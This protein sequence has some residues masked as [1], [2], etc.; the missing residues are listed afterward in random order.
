MEPEGRRSRRRHTRCLS[1]WSSDVC[2]S[3]LSVCEFQSPDPDVVKKNIETCKQFVGLVAEIGG[4]GV[5]VRPNGISPGADLDKTL[6]QIGKALVPCG[7]AAKD[8]GIEIW[9]EV[10]GKTT[11]IPANMQKIM[12]TCDHPSVGVTW[13]SNPEDVEGGSVAKSFE[14]LK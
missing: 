12:K 5:K 13:N 2:S 8:A 4:K 1:D 14:L 7:Q 3:D 10:H 9:V 6:E 11:A